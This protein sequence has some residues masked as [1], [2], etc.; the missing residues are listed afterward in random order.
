MTSMRDLITQEG[1]AMIEQI[2][3]PALNI[4]VVMLREGDE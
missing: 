3:V 1:A 4:C 2:S